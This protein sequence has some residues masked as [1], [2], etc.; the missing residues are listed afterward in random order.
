MSEIERTPGVTQTFKESP[1]LW[2]QI[3]FDGKRKGEANQLHKARYTSL[4]TTT[5]LLDPAAIVHD[6]TYVRFQGR[7]DVHTPVLRDNHLLP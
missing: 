3:L 5:G 6:V 1:Q 4:S 7:L 2:K